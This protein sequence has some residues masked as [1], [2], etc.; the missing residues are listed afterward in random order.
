MVIG[1]G[2]HS[3]AYQISSYYYHDL[4]IKIYHFHESIAPRFVAHR[5]EDFLTGVE[6]LR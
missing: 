3:T 6:V 5:L 4:Y 2:A 1:G